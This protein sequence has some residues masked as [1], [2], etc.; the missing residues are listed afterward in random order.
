MYIGLDYVFRMPSTV[1]LK[2]AILFD[3]INITGNWVESNVSKY[4]EVF[5]TK[6]L[7]NSMIQTV[8]GIDLNH[9]DVA[10]Y[11]PEELGLLTDL[12]LLRI[13]SNRFYGIV[14]HKFNHLKLL[15][16]LDLSNN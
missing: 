5:Y 2:Q 12:A 7:D 10:G 4:T 6:V 16:E 1:A 15:F 11:F 3:P 8:V 14:P 13:N 9:N